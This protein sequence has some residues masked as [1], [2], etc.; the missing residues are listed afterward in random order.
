MVRL[1]Q[2]TRDQGDLALGASPRGSLALFR[3]SQALAV[4]QGRDFVLPDDVKRLVQ[5]TLAHRFIVRPQSALRGYSPERILG[6]ILR[7]TPLD[8]GDLD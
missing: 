7:A 8:I 2:A 6:D 5:P 3:S 1:V 4:I